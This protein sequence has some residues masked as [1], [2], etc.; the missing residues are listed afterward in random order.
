MTVDLVIAV[1]TWLVFIIGFFILGRS[2]AA[3]TLVSTLVYP[4]A[5][6]LFIKMRESSVLHEFFNIDDLVISTLFFG[7]LCGVGCAVTFMGGGSTGGSDII[8]L[9]LSKYVRGLKSSVAIG[10]IDGLIVILG[11]FFLK[12]PV[13]SLY[14]IV[15]VVISAFTI[16][17]VFLGASRALVAEIITSNYE[18]INSAVID[19][20]HRTTTIMSVTGGYSGEDKKMVSVSFTVRQ[21]A[22]L[23]SVISRYDKSAFVTVHRAYEINGEG[24]TR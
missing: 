24:W 17:K 10:I 16:D 13:L 5:I 20:L 15:A 3:K 6:S 12:N 11:L 18:Q 21:Y 19:E 23:M 4:I 7:I 14:G 2:F 1:L 9:I 8:G 22:S